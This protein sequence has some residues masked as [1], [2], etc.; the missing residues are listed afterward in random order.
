MW[1]C[2]NN[3][4]LWMFLGDNLTQDISPQFLLNLLI[5]PPSHSS[6]S[7][8]SILR[9]VM[10]SRRRMMKEE[11][12]DQSPLLLSCLVN[13]HLVGDYPLSTHTT[14]YQGCLHCPSSQ[15]VYL[16]WDQEAFP[17]RPSQVPCLQCS[18]RV[19]LLFSP[20]PPWL[21]AWLPFSSFRNLV[22]MPAITEKGLQQ[23]KW[24]IPQ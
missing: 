1:C 16:P 3:P 12:Q 2:C 10:T 14:P 17:R 7:R 6:M 20:F 22:T 4:W 21:P 9:T 18:P 24:M 8:G 11:L 5:L 13:T 23:C 19:C 15:A